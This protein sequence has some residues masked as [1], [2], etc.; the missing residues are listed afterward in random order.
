MKITGTFQLI[1]KKEHKKEYTFDRSNDSVV[2]TKGTVDPIPVHFTS[3]EP[4]RS[5][6]LDF[7]IDLKKESY[8]VD[9]LINLFTTQYKAS[10][11]P[12][13]QLPA[14]RPVNQP[15]PPIFLFTIEGLR[16]DQTDS[17]EPVLNL[18][19]EDFSIPAEPRIQ[20]NWTPTSIASLITGVYP[21]RHGYTPSVTDGDD[22]S[23]ISNDIV[24]IDEMLSDI[25]YKCSAIMGNNR[26]TPDKLSTDGFYRFNNNEE[27][28]WLQR[29]VNARSKINKLIEYIDEDYRLGWKSVFYWVYLKDTHDPYFPPL[30]YMNDIDF[31]ALESMR[32]NNSPDEYPDWLHNGLKID[33][34]YVE[35]IKN[36][37][38]KSISYTFKQ[39]ERL[40][41]NL[42]RKGIY[43]E[44]LIIICGD[45]GQEFFERGFRTHGSLN[46]AAI[47]P[48]MLIKT[49]CGS[50]WEVP[51]NVDYI[52]ILP[53]IAAEIGTS[54]PTYVQG[55]PL[56]EKKGQQIRITERFSN[57]WYNISIEKGELKAILSYNTDGVRPSKERLDKKPDISEY[58]S[59]ESVRKDNFEDIGAELQAEIKEEMR[60]IC[61]YFILNENIPRDGV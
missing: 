35:K 1:N 38:K 2:N 48:A 54:A 57:N 26:L 14:V 22:H 59:L 56:Q 20:G 55:V 24:S 19:G 42:M 5:L 46:D 32:P 33:D 27:D 43:E 45:H 49:P 29:D 52:D 18:C 9:Y 12:W 7:E 34:K 37:Y 51:E 28:K 50:Q 10:S 21:G 31:A 13:L 47:R 25:G 40:I 16:H 36:Y 3:P 11:E 58:Y 41:H 17:F 15:K 61:K 23:K 39:I 4:A 6:E 30:S 44:S 8:N 53:T 60:A